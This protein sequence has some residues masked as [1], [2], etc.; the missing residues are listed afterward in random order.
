[1]AS[2]ASPIRNVIV[3]IAD[4][5]GYNTLEATRLYLQGLAEGDPRAGAAGRTLVADGAGFVATAQSV[6]PLDT[7][8]TPIPGETGT[9]Q[10]PDVVY[11]PAKNYDFRPVAGSDTVN[12]GGFQVTYPRGFE[13]YEFHRRTYPDSGNTASSIATGEKTYNNAIDVDGAGEPLFSIAEQFHQLGRATGVVST[14][15]FSDATPAATGGAHN[16]ARANANQIAQEMFA[17]GT[18]D[19]IAGTGNPDYNDNGRLRTTPD[20]QW[21]GADLWNSLR[22]DTFRSLDGQSWNL[23]Q[24]RAAIQ[25]AGSGTPTTERLAMIT[26]AFTSSNFNRDGASAPNTT[27]IP[28]SV[29]RL[30]TSP[31]LSELSLAALN[32]LNVDPDGL[33]LSIE[34]GAVDRAMH[35]NNL[36]RMIE[37]Y[38]EFNNSVRTV[39]DWINS[40]T[41]R[42]TFEDTLLIVTAD[43]DHLLF[44]PEGATIPYQPVQP[45]RNGDGVPEF[46]FFSGNHSN[47]II[48]LFAAGAGASLIPSL[49]D[50]VDAF[51]NAQGQRIGSGRNFTDEAELGDFLQAQV[52]LNATAVDAGNNALFGSDAG[53]A[54]NGLAGNDFLD[55]RGGNDTLIGEAG[56]DVLSGGVGD[57]AVLGG[58]GNDTA[59][60][61]VATDGA[62]RTDL[63]EGTDIVNVSAAGAGQTRLTFTSAQVGNGSTVD[64]N[65]M[66]NQDGGLAVRLQA[67]AAGDVLTGPVSR[68]DDEGI[69]FVAATNGLTFD[70][71]DLVSGVARGD[72]FQVV[73]LGTAG[74]DTFTVPAATTAQ[75]Q[76]ATYFNAGQGNDTVTGGAANDFLVGGAGNDTLSGGAGDDGFIGGAGNDTIT[77]GAGNDTAIFNVSTDE[78]DSVNLGEG[79]D[80]VNVSAAAAGQIRLSF[81]SAQVGNGNASDAAGPAPQD[82][83][84]AVRLQ[85][86]GAGD[87]L[88]GAVSR[89]DDEGTSFVA[90]AGTTFDVRDLVSGVQ[91]GDAFEV[92]T[93]GTA[94][95]DILTAIQPARPY[96]FNAG[97]GDD[98]VSG[99]TAND[100]LVGGGGNDRLSGGAGN[101]S[102]IG[103]AG[104]DVFDG[105]TGTDRV[106]FNFALS[107]ASVGVAAN[108]GFTIVGPEG[109]DTVRGIEQIQ[110]T[111]RTL[112]NADGAPLV[113]DL[114]YAIRNPDV[115]AA[116]VDPDT[117]Y[118]QFGFREGRDPNA[119]FSTTG[120]LAANSDVRAAGLNPLTHY[121]GFGF[122]EGRDPGAA[123]DTQGYLAR[124]ADV[125]AANVNPLAHYLEF[126]QSEGRAINA[127]VG[128]AG[129]IGSARGFDA[130]FYL[131]SNPD[132]ARAAITAGGDGFAFARDHFTNFG[133]REGRDANAIFDTD[134]YLAAYADVR[135]AGVNPLT[136]YTQF[137]FREGRDPS[138]GFDTSAYLAANADVRAAGIDPMTHYLQ[139]G[140]Y[141]G[142]SAQA[143]TTFGAGNVG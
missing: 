133:A 82:G 30:E 11:D 102:F 26:Q 15:Q 20:Y 143:D 63:G 101:D 70:V 95:N 132:V 67:E 119:F 105:G 53:E 51:T 29:P 1:M 83:G 136:H 112:D 86:E 17:S 79:A 25:T 7:R 99:G 84:L 22:A 45:D 81:V 23:L 48:P 41:S 44:G 106:I 129:E 76:R 57:D 37:E 6:H 131:L 47:Q 13:G 125:R 121:E 78:T 128:R 113:D 54:L 118:A 117:H 62:D 88:A 80:V 120:Y 59:F 123:F 107:A 65:T 36:G 73:T 40:P 140:L 49:A 135:T 21:I 90:A 94:G 91:R 42:A 69:S 39:V 12:N 139:F 114:F 137:G 92:V 141:E 55:G 16:I 126:G 142:R 61:N 50:Q 5:A 52:R 124:N 58:A 109:S 35:A 115:V 2:T 77:G 33:Y 68:Y 74:N 75:P 66:A 56:N 100:F 10:N 34:G 24:D 122:R 60:F 4:G 27:E 3:M 89:F 130:E 116:G 72:Q 43:H 38:I 85:A 46:R 110:F 98:S 64:T 31:T 97:A 28:F 96:Y 8:T 93:L 9:A 32:R 111:D 14:V 134:G 19:V 138:T 127:A 103:G 18:L 87:A 71:R 104:D 108:G